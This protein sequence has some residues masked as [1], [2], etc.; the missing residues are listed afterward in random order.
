MSQNF[1]GVSKSL[2]KLPNSSK[3]VYICDMIEQHFSFGQFTFDVQRKALLK[4]G[5]PVKIGHKCLILLEVLLV[6][7][8]RAVSK[9]DLI[10][11]AW[12]NANV[13]E[14]NLSV[15]IAALRKCLGRSRTGEEWIATVQRFGYQF[16]HPP[17]NL[18]PIVSSSKTDKNW[19]QRQ[20]SNEVET[21]QTELAL[22]DKPSIAVLPFSNLSGDPDQEYFAD[23]IVEDIITALV[24]FKSL[25]VISSNSTFR[26]R[27]VVDVFDVGRALGAQFI[28][29]GSVRRIGSSLRI[30]AQ[31]SEAKTTKLIWAETFNAHETDLFKIQDE[32]VQ[33]IAGTLVGRVADASVYHARLK[34]PASLAAYELLLKANA[35]NWESPEAK[36]EARRL[37][38]S[39]IRLDPEY[40]T[41]YALLAAVGLREAAYHSCLTDEILE[42]VVSDARKA[43]EIDP[44]D[45]ACHSIFG[46]VLIAC[47]ESELAAE[48]ISRA[49]QL[50]PN[51]PFAMVN[52]GSLFTQLGNPDEAISWFTQASRTD[53]FF[54]PSW[55]QEL[56]ALA[57]FTAR[58]YELAAS[59]FA[60]TAKPSFLVSAIAA[61]S[62]QKLGKSEVAKQA[63][64]RAFQ[65]RPDL[66][67]EIIHA[68]IPYSKPEDESHLRETLRA[69]GVPE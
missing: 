66:N 59:C 29:A 51:N 64:D 57:H 60:R 55:V 11:T 17:T 33:T 35:L 54:D 46:W 39:A 14:S 45:S 52:R 42:T 24:R 38:E 23:G 53:P 30:S 19:E 43:V 2:R 28:V 34:P 9:S 61:A 27:G 37:L 68:L 48:H 69:A 25:A 1:F 58:R 47:R 40:A 10:D 21:V 5:S 13:E 36:A 6:A 22:P 26:S 44:N 49:L 12:N 31:L 3:F 67:I 56:F 18:G 15:Q 32:L 62:L 7:E 4:Q 41:A 65:V 16:V 63:L 50:N 8:G 20:P